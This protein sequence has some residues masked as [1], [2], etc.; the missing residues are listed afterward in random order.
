[1]S[2]TCD[3]GRPQS[4]TKLG[5]EKLV[6]EAILRLSRNRAGLVFM[7]WGKA[8]QEYRPL[9]DERNHLVIASDLPTGARN[10][11]KP[12]SFKGSRPFSRAHKYLGTSPVDWKL[13]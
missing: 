13:A 7:L 5:W 2:L 4:H 1:M 8:A 12:V 6:I 3:V 9:I 10:K 11:K